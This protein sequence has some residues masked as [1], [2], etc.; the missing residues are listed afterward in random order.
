MK[1]KPQ[2][3]GT[4][5]SALVASELNTSDFLQTAG[6]D[7]ILGGEERSKGRARHQVNT[8]V[9]MK[10]LPRAESS[11]TSQACRNMLI[12]SHLR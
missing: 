1:R 6:V 5:G 7:L 8:A 2:K 12:I 10:I 11:L 9:A 3:Q 4:L